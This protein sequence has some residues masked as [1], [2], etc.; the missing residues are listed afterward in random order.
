MHVYKLSAPKGHV[1]QHVICR[2]VFTFFVE[3]YERN[4]TVMHFNVKIVLIIDHR[5]DELR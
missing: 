4:M 3:P 5:I 1:L 2:G